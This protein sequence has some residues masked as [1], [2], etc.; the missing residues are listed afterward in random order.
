MMAPILSKLND[1]LENVEIV[2]FDAYEG[3]IPEKYE[4]TSVPTFILFDGGKEIAR[5][6]GSAPGS[7]IEIWIELS[8]GS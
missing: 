7:V 5:R 3:S 2:K 4:I 6:E 1:D 8:L